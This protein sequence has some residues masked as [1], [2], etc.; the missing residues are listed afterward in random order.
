MLLRLL[1]PVLLIQSAFSQEEEK[2]FVRLLA[3]GEN[4][5]MKFKTINGRRVQQP[6]PPGS[7]PPRSISVSGSAGNVAAVPFTLNRYTPWVEVVDRTLAL[8]LSAGAGDG[9]KKWAKVG[10]PTIPKLAVFV[11]DRSVKNMT[12]N[13]TKLFEFADNLRAYPNESIRVINLTRAPIAF[14][15]GERNGVQVNA[16]KSK[17]FQKEDG[18]IVEDTFATIGVKLPNGRWN[19]IY[20]SDIDLF[21]NQRVT[22]LLYLGDREQTRNKVYTKILS[23]PTFDPSLKK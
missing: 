1:L 19:K 18:A 7:V 2:G 20:G 6:D 22:I 13:N 23:G 9:A 14:K 4:P 10:A 21:N 16:G 17:V 11:K 3:L 12:W 5:T 8:Q 15:L